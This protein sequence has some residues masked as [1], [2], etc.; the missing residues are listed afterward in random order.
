MKTIINLILILIVGINISC[1]KEST[2][3]T[4]PP[5]PVKDY[6]Y[7][8]S[9]ISVLADST[10][11]YTINTAITIN[12]SLD[13]LMNNR[14]GGNVFQSMAI[15]PQGNPNGGHQTF[16]FEMLSSNMNIPMSYWIKV[17]TIKSGGP[18]GTIA[19]NV[20][21]YYTFRETIKDS[22][23]DILNIDFDSLP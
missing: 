22:W 20:Y 6:V 15:R 21:K 16:K 1:K 10:M 3:G 8:N 13:S 14:P 5:T 9:N 18:F 2:G 17:E 19:T 7:F 23:S 11:I 4:M 12:I